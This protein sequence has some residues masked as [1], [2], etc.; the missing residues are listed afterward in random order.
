MYELGVLLDGVLLYQTLR[1]DLSEVASSLSRYLC[2]CSTWSFGRC[3]TTLQ[4]RVPGSAQSA[5][6]SLHRTVAM[7]LVASALTNSLDVLP[8]Y[9]FGL[10]EI[11]IAYP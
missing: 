9:K 7:S 8:F 11:E 1:K 5:L 4:F 10:A 3:R 6:S 2:L